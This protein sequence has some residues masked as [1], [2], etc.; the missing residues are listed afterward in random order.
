MLLRPEEAEVK[1]QS[2]TGILFRTEG[3]KKYKNVIR[4]GT[5][6]QDRI[7]NYEDCQVL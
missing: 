4:L 3:G 2:V 1:E 5:S 7:N 6:K